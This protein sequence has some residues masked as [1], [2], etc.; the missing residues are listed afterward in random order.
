[1]ENL[2]RLS[3]TLKAKTKELTREDIRFLVN[4]YY[5][6]QSY[7]IRAAAQM[8]CVEED[9]VVN[10]V[11]SWVFENMSTFEQQL[12]RA[13]DS[14]TDHHPVGRWAKSIVGIGPVLAAG[15]LAYIDIHKATTVGKIWRYA[16]LDPTVKWEPGMPRPWNSRLK[17]LCY[18][19]GDSFV[20]VSNNPK[21]FYGK[22]Y[23]ARKEYEQRKNEEGAYE[24]QAKALAKF[25]SEDTEPY[26]W[27]SVGKLPPSHITRRA[28]RYAVKL[29]LSHFHSVWYIVEYGKL[30]PEPYPL[31]HLG[32][33]DR[34]HIPNLYVIQE[35]V[36]KIKYQYLSVV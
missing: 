1:M 16:G 15:L 9:N 28:M 14:Y 5:R 36:D 33:I 10:E 31:A 25:Y 26:R 23:K 19:I 17:R 21:D 6:I 24:E 8:R 20:K 35:Y 2:K 18:L 4:S 3:R 29:F 7:R 22:I 34:I 11:I 32:H 27:Y 13:L 30:P 12:K